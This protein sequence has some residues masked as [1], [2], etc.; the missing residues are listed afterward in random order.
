MEKLELG[1][2][3]EADQRGAIKVI[4]RLANLISHRDS[5]EDVET[6]EKG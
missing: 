4:H 6:S 2:T 3:D 1:E 5:K